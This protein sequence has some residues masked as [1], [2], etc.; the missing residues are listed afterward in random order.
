MKIIGKILAFALTGAALALGTGAT[1]QEKTWTKVRIATEGAFAPW[2]FTKPDGTLDGFEI[3]LY[4]DLCKRM[5]VECTIEAQSFDGIIPAPN[6][7]KFD[8]IMAG[9]SATAKREEV[10]AFTQPYGTTGQTFAVLKSGPLV[11]MPLNGK[12]FSLATNEA[13]AAA[14][15]EELKPVLKGKTIGV[16]GS[17]I[18]AN[19]LDKYL[20]GTAEI[21]EYKTTEQHDL[22]L[23]AGRIDLIMA[24]TAYLSGAAAKVGNEEM[25]LVGPRFQGG[26]LGRGSSVGLR[27]SDPELKA[28][29]D[30]AI[31]EAKADGTIEKLSMKYFGFDVTPR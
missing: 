28:L 30:K 12:I 5:K 22:D 6:A 23:T 15:I 18:A 20:K 26:M 7:G 27:K 10:M 25:T 21:R 17:S 9:M 4:K 19:F 2:N 11:N 14:A 13:G 1:A 24:S 3:D 8:A 16:Q 31:T 29:F